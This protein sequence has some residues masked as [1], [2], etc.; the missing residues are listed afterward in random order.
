[1]LKKR[2]LSTK[3]IL[4]MLLLGLVPLT[5]LCC[6]TLI[7]N[8]YGI[9]RL[10]VSDLSKNGTLKRQNLEN[11]IQKGISELKV[12]AAS[13]D[14][15]QS[16]NLLKANGWNRNS[17]KWK[18]RVPNM[19]RFLTTSTNQFNLPAV[20]IIGGNGRIAYSTRK[21]DIGIDMSNR[22]YFKETMQGRVT[23][24]D[25]FY[26]P[27]T[28]DYVTTISVPVYSLGENGDVIAVLLILVPVESFQKMMV[29]GIGKNGVK[30]NAY[31]IDK[32]GTLI[33]KPNLGS[34]EPFKDKINTTAAQILMTN[35]SS[36][37][38]NFEMTSAYKDYRGV[39]VIGYY[40]ILQI[41][42]N[43]FGFI[44]EAESKDLLSVVF[45]LRFLILT[46][47]L[48]AAIIIILTSWLFTR[49]ISKPVIQIISGLSISS[50]QV[51]AA[52]QQLSA[53]S[54]Q[55]SQ[56][57]S[58]QARNIEET[59]ATLEKSASTLQENLSN[60]EQA[61]NLSDNTKKAAEKGNLEMAEMMNS[62]TEITRS[63]GQISK[64]IKIIDDIAFQT[65][66]LALN[67]AIEAARAGEAGMGFAVV[68]EEVRN[69]AQRSAQAANDT[70]VIIEANIGISEQGVSVA[71]KV[72]EALKDITSQAKKVSALME[73]LTLASQNHSQEIK[74][75]ISNITTMQQITNQTASSSEENAA[76]SEELTAQAENLREIV[77]Q[78]QVLVNGETKK[79][80]QAFKNN[81]TAALIG[82]SQVKPPYL[83]DT[84]KK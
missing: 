44:M 21:N 53:A 8:Q 29:D 25:W 58:E 4:I 71:E 57:S 64:I 65:N 35:I 7:T 43:T 63:S 12:M 34:L 31:L 18:A 22:P 77:R 40:G 20:T 14:I 50:N 30:T 79:T 5:L 32:S 19:D 42:A 16:L 81:K 28:K 59:S 78:L 84:N 17:P 55:L 37:H 76:T 3:L 41:G 9:Y 1:M 61:A 24:T 72:R 67:A 47:W 45:K 48:I 62:I 56:G 13:Q 38:N 73:E 27:V 2:N 23:I 33:T 66:I 39:P 6:Y 54:Q 80:K 83:T 70:T 36:G 82:T 69:L 10:S 26:S 49:S 11:W 68:A 15:Y 52:A 75:I 60:T 46:F 74:T 51:A